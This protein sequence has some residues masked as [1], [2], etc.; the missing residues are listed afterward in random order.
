MTFRERINEAVLAFF[1]GRSLHDWERRQERLVTLVVEAVGTALADE[2]LALAHEQQVTIR[3][4]IATEL[5]ERSL[6][7]RGA[8]GAPCAPEGRPTR[9]GQ[10]SVD[11]D[12]KQTPEAG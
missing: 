11:G 1:L 6:P 7:V 9:L 2:W 10:R 4:C 5:R 3:A 8:D 12:R